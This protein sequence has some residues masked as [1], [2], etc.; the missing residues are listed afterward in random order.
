MGTRCAPNYAIIFM[1]EL[2]EAFLKQ[3]QNKPRIWLRFIDD[4]FMVWSH[5]EEQL[6]IMLDELNQFHS[7]IKFTEDRS[8]YGLP[9]MDTFTYIEEGILKTRVYHKPTDNKQYLHYSSCHPL[10]QK[11]SIPYGLLVRAKR[12][13]T[14]EEHFTS[15]ARSI[16]QKLRERKYPESILERAVKKILE[17]TRQQLLEPKVK[18]EDT[19]I[20]YITTYNPSNPKMKDISLKHLYLLSRMKRNPITQEQVQIVYRKSQNL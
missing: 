1:A 19:R 10:Q 6:K 9:F 12:I 16:I 11:N 13:C 18:E 15:E 2:E 4:I 20:R 5:G 17:I 3:T 7:Q 14:K 8:D